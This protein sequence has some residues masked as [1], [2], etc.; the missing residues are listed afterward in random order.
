[1]DDKTGQGKSALESLLGGDP[2]KLADLLEAKHMLVAKTRL[3][4]LLVEFR[5]SGETIE[6]LVEAIGT[7]K[8]EIKKHLNDAKTVLN[9]VSD[10]S[11]G[12]ISGL[13]NYDTFQFFNNAGRALYNWIGAQYKELFFI[14]EV[15]NKMMKPQLSRGIQSDRDLERVVTA[16]AEI[17][18][19]TMS[20]LSNMNQGYEKIVTETYGKIRTRYQKLQRK[21]GGMESGKK[22]REEML[23]E[24]LFGEGERPKEES[25]TGPRI[26]LINENC[27][28]TDAL[29]NIMHNLPKHYESVVPVGKS[30]KTKVIK[31]LDEMEVVRV[32][33]DMVDMTKRVYVEMLRDPHL[34]QATAVQLM[35]HFYTQ[36]KTFAPLLKGV[37]ESVQNLEHLRV[38][39]VGDDSK[40]EVPNPAKVVAGLGRMNFLSI[41][42]SRDEI[43]PRTKIEKDYAQARRTLLAQLNESLTG[44]TK[45]EGDKKEEF[46]LLAVRKAIS[47]K[48]KLDEIGQTAREKTLKSDIRGENEFYVGTTGRVGEFKAVRE[49]SPKIRYKDIFGSSFGQAKQHVEEVVNLA[50]FPYV[51]QTSAPRG[52][53]KSNL[54][55][56]GPYGCGKSEFA[57]AVAGDRR[58]IGLYVSVADVLT[59]YMHESVKNVKRVWEEARNL[60]Q[61]S[62]L[63]KPV[64]IIQDEFDAWFQQGDLG[65][66]AADEQQI[67]RVL[68]EM[69]D[70]LVEYE[71]VFTIALTNRPG[72]IPDAILRRFK[73]VDVVGQ[74]SHTERTELFKR[75]LTNGMPVARGITNDD[76]TRWAKI[77]DDAPGDVLGK[78]A[79]EVHFKY[80]M[81][82]RQSN[83]KGARNLERYLS[84]KAKEGDLAPTDYSYAKRQLKRFRPVTKGEIDGAV[85]YMMKQPAIQKMINAARD[86]YQEAD[87]IMHGLMQVNDGPGIGFGAKQ[88]SQIWKK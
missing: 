86:V 32:A 58:V 80:M 40:Q 1:M 20:Q 63:T 11:F 46:A 43:Q 4:S 37:A 60:R 13:D 39:V 59:A 52:K 82:F 16:I 65:H 23:M 83:P 77:L 26:E 29:V 78:I 53:I 27:V 8:E 62:R 87:K 70:G 25:G 47:L 24:L 31:K 18:R 9:P 12:E 21:Y 44:I 50:S 88:Q 7:K 71:G 36:Y 38:Q 22:S 75:F 67:E 34:L 5:Q 76:Y 73:Y 35:G 6:K 55:L 81:E 66:R 2:Q 56:I 41:Q 54:L 51:V 69:L 85:E 84:G 68:Q 30:G 57:R 19:I 61:G 3:D 48:E 15:Y 45:T 74:L 72:Q 10:R 64:A 28:L 17:T 49:P 42:P 33:Q 79:D 14:S